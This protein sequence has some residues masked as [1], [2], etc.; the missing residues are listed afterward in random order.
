[1]DS[2]ALK[3]QPQLTREEFI[4]RGN[5]SLPTTE[6][7][8]LI[9]YMRTDL[10]SPADLE[11]AQNLTDAQE[12][13]QQLSLIAQGAYTPLSYVEGFPA[14]QDGRPFWHKLPYEPAIAFAAFE[15]YVE[16][17]DRKSVV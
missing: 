12:R 11:H 14:Q 2:Q 3:P 8:L 5:R 16:Q 9:G 15:R 4:A 13:A 6:T 7:G 10:I 17:G 1:M